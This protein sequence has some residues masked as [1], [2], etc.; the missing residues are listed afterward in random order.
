[1]KTQ[2]DM[3]IAKLKD[4]ASLIVSRLSEGCFIELSNEREENQVF[5]ELEIV[6][7][8]LE[9]LTE[10]EDVY[11]QYQQLFGVVVPEKKYLSEA[12]TLF[13]K[14]NSVWKSTTRYNADQLEWF[15]KDFNKL[16]V[17]EINK[18]VQAYF[19]EA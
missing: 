1:M 13:D 4:N 8:Q 7:K 17:E 5:T 18:S 19:T 6:K 10:S 9:Q 2:L 3:N 16:D 12:Q 15:D 11:H 14:T